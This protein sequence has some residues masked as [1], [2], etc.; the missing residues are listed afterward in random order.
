MGQLCTTDPTIL[1]REYGYYDRDSSRVWINEYI[2]ENTTS[3]VVYSWVDYNADNKIGNTLAIKR[4]FYNPHGGISIITLLTDSIIID[5]Y[6]PIVGATFLTK[7][8]P[9]DAFTYI[10]INNKTFDNHI[11]YLKESA[12]L[13]IT[14]SPIINN[15]ALFD[16]NYIVIPESP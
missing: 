16:K 5:D 2:I 6:Q 15:D 9:G 3:E 4:F 11:F 14:G 7:I 1:R 12:L 10:I 13:D 8:P